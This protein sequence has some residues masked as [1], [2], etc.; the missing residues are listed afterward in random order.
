MAEAQTQSEKPPGWEMKNLHPASAAVLQREDPPG[1][2]GSD[3]LQEESLARL[4][5]FGFRVE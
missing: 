5:R 1:I 2:G 4:G 3:A